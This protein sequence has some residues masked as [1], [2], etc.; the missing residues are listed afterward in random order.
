MQTMPSTVGQS[1]H[2]WPQVVKLIN[3]NR[4]RLDC[5]GTFAEEMG[6]DALYMVGVYEREEQISNRADGTRQARAWLWSIRSE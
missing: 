2:I 1:T 3:G 5:G 4:Q 6:R